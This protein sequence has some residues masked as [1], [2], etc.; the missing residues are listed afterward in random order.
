[1]KLQHQLFLDA[2]LK[3]YN[4][5]S[6]YGNATT[7]Y[8]K[9]YGPMERSVASSCGSK[10]LQEASIKKF[11]AA[12]VQKKRTTFDMT[13]EE[14]LEELK[15]V[16]T[17]DLAQ[18]YDEENNTLLNIADFPVSARAAVAGIEVE[19]LFERTAGGKM[20]KIGNTVKVKLH[21]KIAALQAINN[22][23]GFNAPAKTASTDKDGNNI[24]PLSDKH[25]DAIIDALRNNK[26]EEKDVDE[27]RSS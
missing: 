13:K 18:I 2:Y 24:T 10:L 22:V 25:V 16:G 11:I 9:A 14:V 3:S 7:A 27:T 20:E 8:I 1:M 26:I 21:N 6:G 4:Y 5:H 15:S 23:K 17:F 19:E 12:W